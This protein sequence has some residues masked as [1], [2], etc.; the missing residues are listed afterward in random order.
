MTGSE[1][2]VFRPGAGLLSGREG[3]DIGA[4]TGSGAIVA[5]AVLC[6]NTR[7]RTGAMTIPPPEISGMGAGER[8]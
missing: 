5:G 4:A 3:S 6:E 1:T 2:V 8:P 7:F